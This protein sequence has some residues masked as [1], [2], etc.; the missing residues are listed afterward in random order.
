MSDETARDVLAQPRPQLSGRTAA[1]IA[2]V[3]YQRFADL[4]DAL[5][6]ADWSRP[7]ACPP[8]DVR[9]LAAHVLGATEANAS[10]AEMLHQLRRGRRGA[11]VGVDAV[12]DVQV[13]E[14]QD[15]DPDELR[16]RFRRAVP[17]TVRW[18]ARWSRLA[19]GVPMR[20]GAPVHETWPV[21]YLMAVIYTRDVWMHRIDISGAVGRVPLL[22]PQHDG[23]VVADVVADWARRHRQPF[24][25]TLAGP[26]GGRFV[27]GTAGSP[28]ALDAVEFCRTVSGRA[29]GRGLLATS[30]PF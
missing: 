18:R 13:R 7:T 14:R 28:V 12:S 10:P 19:G 30:V 26:A 24:V 11:A 8:W 5:S 15:L 22:T 25:L 23:R 9:L 21:R 27:A 3:E 2:G 16:R 20:V 6:P 4:L 29:P 1:A 17:A